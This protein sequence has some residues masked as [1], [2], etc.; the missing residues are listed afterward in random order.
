MVIHS[1]RKEQVK[2]YT[3]DTNSCYLLE[4]NLQNSDI[5]GK[6]SGHYGSLFQC[7]F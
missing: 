7:I 4:S 2:G 1:M 6:S 5:S 3:N